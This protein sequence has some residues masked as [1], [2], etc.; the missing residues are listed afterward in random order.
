ML[1]KKKKCKFPSDTFLLVPKIENIIK[2][3]NYKLWG[4]KLQSN[5]QLSARARHRD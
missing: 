5:M 4:Y 2:I 1:K 3:L